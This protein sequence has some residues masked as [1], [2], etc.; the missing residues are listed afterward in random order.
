M[1]R[2]FASYQNRKPITL[3]SIVCTSELDAANSFGEVRKVPQ[4]AKLILREH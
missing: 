1:Y 3:Q 2:S 4:C